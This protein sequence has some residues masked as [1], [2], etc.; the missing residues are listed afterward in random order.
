MYPQDDNQ[1]EELTVAKVTE[2]E[3]GF[4]IERTDGFSFYVLSKKVA[5]KV[6][7]S[8]RFY[9]LGT[10]VRGVFIDGIE[11]FYRT[12]AQDREHHEI[13]MYGADATEW[14]RRWDT[15]KLCWSISMGGFGPGYEQAIQI[16]AAEFL[17][18]MLTSD[19]HPEEWDTDKEVWNKARVIIER[20]VEEREVVKA[21]GCSGAQWGAAFNL[22]MQLYRRGPRSVMNDKAVKDRHIQVCRTF[23]QG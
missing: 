3:D 2:H 1:F 18:V 23:P 11:A 12:E 22:G 9:G 15:N 20:K 16:I 21:I 6:G 14:L 10:N 8:A 13:E 4:E 19:F 17:R 5:P 7:S